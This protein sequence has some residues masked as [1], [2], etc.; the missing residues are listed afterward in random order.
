MSGSERT[1]AADQV[2]SAIRELTEELGRVPSQAE[3]TAKKRISEYY[4]GIHFETWNAA[5]RAAGHQPNSNAEERR[6][7]P[8]ALLKDWASVVRAQRRIPTQSQYRARGNHSVTSFD[9]HFGSWSTIAMRFRAFA[10]DKEE[11]NDVLSLLP[12]EQPE[13]ATTGVQPVVHR[14]ASTGRHVKLKGRPTY[15]NPIHF[16]GL[17]HEPVN[18]QGVVFLFGMLAHELGYHGLSRLR[19]EARD[20][21]RRLAARAY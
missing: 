10:Q 11:W 17:R 19:S 16:R 4:V 5:V 20:C 13:G 21:W 14:A 8:V 18:E 7:E 6:T 3:F 2:L 12:P 15:G 1:V 9:K